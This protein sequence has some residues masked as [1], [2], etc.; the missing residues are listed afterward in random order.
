MKVIFQATLIAG[1]HTAFWD[2][3]DAIGNPAA[4]GVYL[5][6]LETGKG[7]KRLKMVLLR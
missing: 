6:A 5:F 4:S 3:R 7:S 2:G 1:T